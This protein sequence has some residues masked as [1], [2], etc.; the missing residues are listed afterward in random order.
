MSG[1]KPP[2]RAVPTNVITGFLGVGKT[3][4]IL[5]L[6]Q[7][8]PANQ[9]WAVLVNEFGEIGVDG[10]LMQGHHSEE[11]S[12]FIREVPG[13]CMCCAGGLPMQI[14]LNQLLLI[15]RPDRLLIEPTGLGHPREVL[16]VLTSGP[17][18][19]VLS[20]EQVITLVNARQL[21]DKRYTENQTF[22][23][24]IAVADIVVGNKDDLYQPNDREMLQSYVQE[25]AINGVRVVYTV[26]GE[27]DYSLLMGLSRSIGSVDQPKKSHHHHQKNIPAVATLP[28]CGYLKKLNE[29]DGYR[30]VGWRFREDKIFRRDALFSFLSGIE[31]ERVKAVMNT[32]NG[33]FGYNIV[34]GSLTELPLFGHGQSCIE[35]INVSVND[36]W[37]AQLLQC[38]TITSAE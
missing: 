2:I 5:H 19:E 4:S 21:S 37:E 33:V 29:G 16:Q 24:Q 12:V 3:T 36:D 31:A 14:V 13:G 15:A 28:A 26:N 9:R 32:E 30:S 38:L 18:R 8:K 1:R 17:Y 34:D 7:N 11:Q 23:Q 6:L 10:A 22:N 20:V 35:F 25:N 27:L